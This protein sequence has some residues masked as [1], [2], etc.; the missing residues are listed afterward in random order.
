MSIE[1]ELIDRS[2]AKCELCSATEDLRVF[3]VPPYTSEEATADQSIL[4]CST[5]RQQVS[6]PDKVDANHWRCLNESMWSLVPSVQVM[7]WRML[8][9]LR[10]EGWPLDLLDMLMLDDDTLAWAKSTEVKEVKEEEP[11]HVDSHGAALESG[12]SVVLTKD[13][14]VKGASF[15]AKRGT[16]VRN[17]NLVQNNPEQIE[18]RV[19][20]QQIVI[21]TKF[22]KKA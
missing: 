3:T 16:A 1:Q 18:G 22:V 2:E 21:L 9:R 8:N 11:R 4:L 20:G 6:N 13:L 12:D 15:T 17:I 7:S 19:N 5:C 14:N 10:T